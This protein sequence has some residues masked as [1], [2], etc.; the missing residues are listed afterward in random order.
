MDWDIKKYEK[1]GVC[2]V[3]EA[4]EILGVSIHTIH[5]MIN[6]GTLIAWRPNPDAPRGKKL[7]YRAQVAELRGATRAEGIGTA[8]YLQTDFDFL[9]TL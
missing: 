5:N 7:L 2:S 9:V 8:Q 4:A 6:W 1:G 3:R